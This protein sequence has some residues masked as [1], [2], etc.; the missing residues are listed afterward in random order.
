MTVAILLT[1]LTHP[2]ESSENT[3]ICA[4]IRK[5]VRGFEELLLA[6]ILDQ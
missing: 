2:A 3:A 5:F 6:A 1:M 4:K